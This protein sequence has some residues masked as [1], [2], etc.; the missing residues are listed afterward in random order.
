MKQG[1][2]AVSSMKT[3]IARVIPIIAAM[4]PLPR[5]RS[6]PS[7]GSSV[8]S[9]VSTISAGRSISGVTR[10]V[11]R[12]VSGSMLV[13]R[14]IVDYFCIRVPRSVFI[15]L[16][17]IHTPVRLTSRVLVF[18]RVVEVKVTTLLLIPWQ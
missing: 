15:E 5:S 6:I 17:P 16:R 10:S 1:L 4:S 11:C 2:R 7:A 13:A 12:S 14:V 9:L 18:I 8:A 3:S